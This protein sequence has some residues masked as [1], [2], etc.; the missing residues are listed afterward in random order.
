MELGGVKMRP[1]CW[2]ILT[3]SITAGKA[4]AVHT[5]FWVIAHL[6][7]LLLVV[8]GGIWKILDDYTQ[9]T[10]SQKCFRDHLGLVLRLVISNTDQ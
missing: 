4:R 6:C 9:S 10:L 1:S 7:W 5:D 8:Y 2:S 3:A